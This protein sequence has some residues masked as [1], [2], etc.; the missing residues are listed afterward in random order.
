MDKQDR[1]GDLIW[2]YFK[3]NLLLQSPLQ[4]SIDEGEI[5][6][7]KIYGNYAWSVPWTQHDCDA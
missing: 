4:A 1:Q 3:N 2:F 6:H 5:F 7:S